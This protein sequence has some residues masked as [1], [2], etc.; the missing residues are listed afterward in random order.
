MILFDKVGQPF[1]IA[2]RC[3]GE[4]KGWQP[5]IL[6]VSVNKMGS[7]YF[8]PVAAQKIPAYK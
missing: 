2:I 3:G 1:V 5:F 8:F 6:L 7:Y 4:A